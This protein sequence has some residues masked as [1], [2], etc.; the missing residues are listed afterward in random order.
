[1][2]SQVT[3]GSGINVPPGINVPFGTFD[4]R[5]K[6]APWKIDPSCLK[7]AIFVAYSSYFN[8]KVY[9]FKENSS[10]WSEIRSMPPGKMSGN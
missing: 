1:M 7:I 6:C 4:K 2:Q 8:Q 9:F 3:L 5:N 10:L